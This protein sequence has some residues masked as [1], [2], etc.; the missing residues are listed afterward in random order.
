M[1]AIEVK[2]VKLRCQKCEHEWIPR[3]SDVRLCPNCKTA[4]W[5][6]PRD[7]PKKEN[8]NVKIRRAKGRS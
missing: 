5:D 1:S 2:M 4:Y 6:V 7:N 3:K 8:N